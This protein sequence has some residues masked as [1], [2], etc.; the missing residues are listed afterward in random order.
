M[1]KALSTVVLVISLF[2]SSNVYAAAL[3]EDIAGNISAALNAA[4]T[5]AIEAKTAIMEAWDHSAW[6]QQATDMI[7]SIQS[8]IDAKNKLTSEITGLTSYVTNMESAMTALVAST[9]GSDVDWNYAKKL[10]D[11][12][13]GDPTCNTEGA[14]CSLSGLPYTGPILGQSSFVSRDTLKVDPAT[15]GYVNILGVSVGKSISQIAREA[16]EK[17]AQDI[18]V[19]NEMAR[20]AFVQSTNRMARLDYLKNGLVSPP[21]GDANDLK[22]T[23]DLHAKIQAEEA[24]LAN[25]QNKLTA[26]AVLQ[27]S[28]RDMYEQ[29]KKEI[30]AYLKSGDR[31]V[32]VQVLPRAAILVAT[33]AAYAALNASY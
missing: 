17:N 30:A 14:A 25:D 33:T 6:V 4:S 29:R 9:P 26:L 1:K 15:V 21:A 8:V 12:Y 22:Y 32:G 24:Y 3:V 5:A 20:E 19:I 10:P 23:A 27:Q 7:D 2:G 13:V 28:Q 11:N 31:N 16:E 18:A